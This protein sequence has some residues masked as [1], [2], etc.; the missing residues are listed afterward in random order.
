ML[1]PT[2]VA[3]KCYTC[4]ADTI[5]DCN[6]TQLLQYCSLDIYYPSCFTVS[7]KK[8]IEEGGMTFL[9]SNDFFFIIATPSF[10]NVDSKWKKNE[11]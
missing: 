5:D 9:F 7:Y 8:I 4:I 3:L 2:V 10:Q 11:T 1:T 6:K